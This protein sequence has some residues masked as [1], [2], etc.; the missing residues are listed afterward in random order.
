MKRTVGEQDRQI[1]GMLELQIRMDER[2]KRLE[3][4]SVRTRV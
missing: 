3:G 4:R 2:I 1:G